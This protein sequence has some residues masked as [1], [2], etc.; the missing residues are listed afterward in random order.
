MNLVEFIAN[1]GKYCT[2]ALEWFF[3]QDVPL[4]LGSLVWIEILLFFILIL[5]SFAEAV[6]RFMR[7]FVT[8]L[9]L[10]ILMVLILFGMYT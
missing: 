3:G 1:G 6:V 2:E 8:I 4:W 7:Y 5:L 10:I 9:A